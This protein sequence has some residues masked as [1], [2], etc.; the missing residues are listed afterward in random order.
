MSSDF[1]SWRKIFKD[2]TNRKA[3]VLLNEKGALTSEELMNAL[4]MTPALLGY[5]LRALNGLVDTVDDKYVLSEKGKQ[6]YQ[7]IDQ[8]SEHAGASRRWK[9]TWLASVIS[10]IAIAPL[11]VY[12]TNTPTISI[13]TVIFVLLGLAYSYALKVKPKS[14]GRLTYITLG[15]LFIGIFLWLLIELIIF[16]AHYYARFPPDSTSDHIILILSLVVCYV[17]G[18]VVGELI[19]KKC[20]YQFPPSRTV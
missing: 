10:C 1:K 6:A 3:L 18:G 5:H 2:E 13:L 8:L 15:A 12:I 19:G 9:I 11:L 16:D 17:I 20:K 4:N 7:N 14:I